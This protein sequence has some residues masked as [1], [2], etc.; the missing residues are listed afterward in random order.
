MTL[1]IEIQYFPSIISINALLKST[2][3]DFCVYE[4]WQRRSFRNRTIIAT[5]NGLLALSIPVAGGRNQSGLYRDI[6]IDYRGRWQQQHWRS[7]FSAYG[8]SPWFF[9]YADGLEDLYSKR[10]RFL[11]DWN[12]RCLDWLGLVLKWKAGPWAEMAQ[13]VPNTNKLNSGIGFPSAWIRHPDPGKPDLDLA[14]RILPGNFQDPIWSLGPV[15][16]QV[17]ADRFGYQPGLSILDLLFCLGPQCRQW[18]DQCPL[19]PSGNGS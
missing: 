10:D 11:V 18:L 3:V 19:P 17:F 16:P 12:F 7:V 8:K 6:E 9:Q 2:N 13:T 1:K 14:D 15:Y 5:A 4:N